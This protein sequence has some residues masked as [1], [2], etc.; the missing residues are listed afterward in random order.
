MGVW[1][2]LTRGALAGAAGTWFMDA[3]TTGLAAQQPQEVTAKEQAAMPRG[4]SA[5]DNLVDRVAGQLGVAISEE[6]R[7]VVT[8]AVHYAL[9]VVPG[10]LYAVLRRRVPLV[11]AANGALYGTLLWAINDEYLN[12]TL[13]LAGPA[14][15]YPTESHVRGLVGHVALGTATDT[16]LKVLPG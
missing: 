14:E 5:V 13:G 11:G 4:R 10:A 2:D 7:P 9:G 16:V 15:A 3:A 6:Q 8:Q 1:F 12:M